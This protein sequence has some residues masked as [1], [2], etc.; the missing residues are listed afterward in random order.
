MDT[1]SKEDLKPS[2]ECLKNGNS[3][4][5][6]LCAIAYWYELY[7]PEPSEDNIFEEIKCYDRNPKFKNINVRSIDEIRDFLLSNVELL[8][9]IIIDEEGVIDFNPLQQL[10]PA[11]NGRNAEYTGHIYK[12]DEDK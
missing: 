2:L 11:N 5:S 4:I 3:S 12:C 8:N 10:N 9:S 6:D 7:K 1:F